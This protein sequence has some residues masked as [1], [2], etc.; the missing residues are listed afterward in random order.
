[1][2]KY[3]VKMEILTI[4]TIFC[5]NLSIYAKMQNVNILFTE[6]ADL[7]FMDILGIFYKII[8]M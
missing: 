3:I 1:M 4:I 5:H 6:N 7:R 8:K 2:I